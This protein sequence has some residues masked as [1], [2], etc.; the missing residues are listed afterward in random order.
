MST[1]AP[2]PLQP[3]APPPP[4][5]VHHV[6]AFVVD[7]LEKY[8]Q[9]HTGKHSFP[10]LVLGLQGPQ[11]SGKSYLASLLPSTLS[12]P[13]YGSLRTVTLSLDDL[14]LPHSG[15]TDLAS[16]HPANALLKGRGQAGT[17]E[18]ALGLDVLR[19]LKQGGEG[20]V[21]V[22]VFEKSLHAGEGDRLPKEEWV[23]VNNPEAVDVVVLEGWMLGFRPCPSPSLPELYSAAKSSPEGD[24]TKK[25]LSID[26]CPPFFLQHSLQD[27]QQVERFLED[28]DKL[29]K[30]V[31]IVVQIR[32]EKMGYVW[33]WRLEQEHNMKA[34][35][36]GIGMT[37]DQVKQF[38]S[39]YMPGY[40]LWLQGL[41]STS[42]SWVGKG[43]RVVVGKDRGVVKV[44]GF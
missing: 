18:I 14:Y 22:P 1:H 8:R 28:Y 12:S 10:P 42:S 30:E 15:L 31:D 34:K 16:S 36:G 29:W 25:L 5:T 39:R 38:I 4:S 2:S 44:E 35:N 26:Y 43:L 9:A 11:G 27:L 20:P 33:E 32:P 7:H 6:A 13:T 3:N 24:D 23:K 37:D 40:E 17:H 41:S 19:Q 21:E